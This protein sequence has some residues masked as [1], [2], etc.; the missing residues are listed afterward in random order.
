MATKDGVQSVEDTTTN[1]PITFATLDNLDEVTQVRLYDGNG[2][3]ISTV[4]GVPQPPSASLL[5]SRTD[6]SYDD[7]G[8][9]SPAQPA[10]PTA[11]R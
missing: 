10:T 1:R 11:R 4:S 3:T 6:I 9:S 8:A 7:Q 5:Q 2:V